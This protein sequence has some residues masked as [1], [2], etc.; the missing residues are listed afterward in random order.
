MAK[1][2]KAPAATPSPSKINEVLA[3]MRREQGASLA[4]LVE[5]TGWLPH[6]T[7]AALTGLRK[8][9]HAIVKDSVDGVTRYTIAAAAAQ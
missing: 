9:G 1:N 8:K 7:R 2:T 4:E 6:S 5:A 3:L